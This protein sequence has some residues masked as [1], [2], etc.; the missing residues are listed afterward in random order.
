MPVLLAN[1]TVLVSGIGPGLGREVAL[2]V[3]RLGADVAVSARRREAVEELAGEIRALGRRA[4][5]VVA[6][7]TRDADCAR[8]VAEAVATFGR[9]DALVNNAY[10]AGSYVALADD[11]LEGW[12]APFEVNVLGTLRLS[13]AALG[14]MA[15][16]GAGS[17]VMVNSMIVRKP[18]PTMAGYAAS[19]AAL[20]A[21]TQTLAREAGPRGVRVNSVLPGYIWG[22][23]LEGYFAAQAKARGVTAQAVYDE[24]ARDLSLGHIPTSADVADAVVFFA[25]DLS[26]AITGASLDV[27][28]G[29]EMR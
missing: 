21:A 16:R 2:A 23:A 10:H 1:R 9:I 18:L 14:E 8:A 28:G 7:V 15:K 20:L 29:Q 6:D 27:N 11:D 19:K 13:K 17:I 4:M 3:A 5:P 12:R 25:R 22:P 26:R 24:V